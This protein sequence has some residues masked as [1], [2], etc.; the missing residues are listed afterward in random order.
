MATME[1][2]TDF[3]GVIDSLLVAQGTPAIK[4]GAPIATLSAATSATAPAQPTA[5]ATTPEPDWPEDTPMRDRTVRD[6]L[7]DALTEEMR[8]NEDVFV[9]GEEVAQN[10]GAF[11]VT[12]G[13]LDEF[14]SRRVVD[15]PITETGFT[16]L[17][18]GAAF[19]GLRPVVEF[20]SFSFALQ[21]LDQ[22]I[23]TAAKTH[24]MS[25]GTLDCPIVFRGPH[26]ASPRVGA[27]HAQD[28]AALFAHIPGLKVI[29]PYAA[30]DAK[31][32][33]KSAI[34][35]R[36]PVIF[37]EN[38]ELY[39]DSGPVPV[40]EDFT[41]PLG[42]ARLQR[43]GTDVTLVSFG[44]AMRATLAAAD[45][46]ADQGIAAEVIDLRCLRPLDHA[47]VL[48]SGRKT[49]R[50]GCVEDGFPMGSIGQQLATVVMQQG[51]DD[52][53]APV[54]TVNGADLPM[55]Y[56]ENIEALARVTPDQIVQ[57]ALQ[58]CYRTPA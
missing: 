54:A 33:L 56:A 50:C 41:L 16:G 6:A 44:H 34:R 1:C 5:S 47:T 21:A 52:L 45:L 58:V 35:D 30:S 39:G 15:A 42:K 27:Q 22:I 19:A 9:I 18:I 11:K 28:F 26:G 57:A 12:Q 23:N 2:E 4:V 8:A 17:G 24:Y 31:G 38:E 40:M 53:D 37:L 51:F 49:H 10:Q 43:T 32:L 3:D 46:L 20:M 55:P 29:A 36:S 7:R 25:G 14:G 48:A 13:L